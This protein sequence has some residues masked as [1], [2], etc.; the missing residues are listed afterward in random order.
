MGYVRKK[1]VF[2]L[3]FEDEDLEGLVVKATTVSTEQLLEIEGSLSQIKKVDKDKVR[4]ILSTF[5]KVL[6]S[7]NLE[8]EEG[9]PVP[10]SLD[11]LLGQDFEFVLAI[12]YGWI[13]GVSSVAAPLD[14]KSS[15]GVKSHLESSLLDMPMELLSASPGI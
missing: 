1:K 3:N 14:K 9:A 6:V 13:E 8:D 11:G 2:V 12:L 10:C 15:N 7:W 5:A 4:E